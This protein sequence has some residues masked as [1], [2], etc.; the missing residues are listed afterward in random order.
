MSEQEPSL[1][2]RRLPDR[3][4]PQLDEGRQAH[5]GDVQRSRRGRA[6]S[7]EHRPGRRRSRPRRQLRGRA[8]HHAGPP[9]RV[10]RRDRTRPSAGCRRAATKPPVRPAPSRFSPHPPRSKP[11][12]YDLA[13]VVGVEQMK[14]RRFRPRWRLPRY[15]R[16]VRKG[17]EG[18]LLPL[19]EA[20]R[21][22]RRRVRQALRAQGRTPRAHLRDQLR[23]R[24]EE[25]AR[26][27]PRL[28]HERRA[29]NRTDRFNCVIGGRIKITDCSQVTDGA[30]CVFLAS[31]RYA[32][33]YAKAHNSPMNSIPQI[34]GWGHHTAPI[35]FDD[36]V[37]ESADNPY[38]LPHT[39]AAIVDALQAREHRRLLGRSTPSRRTTASPPP[40][41]W[42]STTSA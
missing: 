33:K 11:S 8:L 41:T 9:R 27:D 25:P 17:S 5:L 12:R 3:L 1:H 24:A 2:P 7:D 30:I 18:R 29:C 10:P 39:R 37:A 23:Q 19:P 6:R 38:V 28:V 22:P 16:L 36:K 40:S 34:L 26:P 4:R 15:G 13:M 32:E 35:L 14:T 31:R 21:P 20:L 42:P